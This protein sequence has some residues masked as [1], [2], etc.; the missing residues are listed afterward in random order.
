MT[1]DPKRLLLIGCGHMG[2]ALVQNLPA[3]KYD[4]DIVDPAPINTGLKATYYQELKSYKEKAGLVVL[5]VKPQILKNMYK[6]IS[7]V[8]DKETLLVSIAAGIACNTLQTQFSGQPVIRAMPNTPAAIGKAITVGVANAF[9]NTQQKEMV[10]TFF[11]YSG[12]FI[13]VEDE[14]L[15]YAVTALSGSGPAYLFYTIEALAKA[16]QD[17]GLPEKLAT[18]LARQTVI[19]ASSLFEENADKTAQELR[20]AVTS[21]G[22]TT[23]AALEILMHEKTGLTELYKQTLQKAVQRSKDLAKS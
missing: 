11:E 16:G 13:W 6:E 14:N 10:K 15:M 4:L 22:G 9:V 12:S 5:A 18:Q 8:L 2:A 23:E 20:Q 17:I 19:G 7:A 21:K 1:S 3:H